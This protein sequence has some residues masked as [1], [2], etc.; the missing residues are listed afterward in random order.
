MKYY[1]LFLSKNLGKMLQNLP[2]AAVVIGALR[3]KTFMT[4]SFG[5]KSNNMDFFIFVNVFI[6]VNFC[7][8]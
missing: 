3:V 2:S 7:K 1:T 8:I 4:T 6:N 5:H